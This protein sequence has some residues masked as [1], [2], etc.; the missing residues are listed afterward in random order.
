MTLGA[1]SYKN[2]VSSTDFD[3]QDLSFYDEHT[4]FSAV[5]ELNLFARIHVHENVSLHVG[6][7][8]LQAYNVSRAD[9]NIRY[10]E[11]DNVVAARVESKEKTIWT[12]GL[13]AGGQITF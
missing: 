1:N 9:E 2:T 8:G 13:T 11:I 4:T 12:Y 7:T 10:Q 6:W 3:T 5:A